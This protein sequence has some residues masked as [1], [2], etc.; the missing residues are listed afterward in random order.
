MVTEERGGRKLGGAP[1]PIT[2]LRILIREPAKPIRERLMMLTR[3]KG[4]PLPTKPCRWGTRP[5]P[6]VLDGS[7]GLIERPVDE[8]ETKKS[9]VSERAKPV[10]Y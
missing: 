3:L 8:Q 10:F 1:D 2:I 7:E 6:Q 5:R 4:N 9:S